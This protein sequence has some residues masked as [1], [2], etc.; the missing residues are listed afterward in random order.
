MKNFIFIVTTVM[1]TALAVSCGYQSIKTDLGDGLTKFTALDEKETVVCGVSKNEG[2]TI[3]LEPLYQDIKL[4]GKFLIAE[5]EDQ[6]SQVFD[7]N[8][9]LISELKFDK[10]ELKTYSVTGDLL[11]LKTGKDVY[12][13]F[14]KNKK[15]V[16]PVSDYIMEPPFCFTKNGNTWRIEGLMDN[17]FS[18]IYIITDKKTSI[19]Y[20]LGK[21]GKVWNL[22]KANG[23]LIRKVSERSVNKLQVAAIQKYTN[24]YKELDKTVRICTIYNID[25][26]K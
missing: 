15:M 19:I 23:T 25:L 7:Q 20:L 26:Y 2:K 21:E 12:L 5:N 9:G 17:E 8:G 14:G 16:G 10:V 18:N 13:Y 4:L 24:Q 6:K 1:I 3:I 22:Y 11:I